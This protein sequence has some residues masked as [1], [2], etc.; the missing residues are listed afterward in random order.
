MFLWGFTTVFNKSF[1]SF[2][3]CMGAAIIVSK[4]MFEKVKGFDENIFLT[5][6]DQLFCK[7]VIE[8]NGKV[9][10]LK[11]ALIIHYGHDTIKNLNSFNNHFKKSLNYFLSK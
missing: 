8:N 3:H 2:N 10:Y 6:E 11:N 4:E 1:D 5:F 7:R 9:I